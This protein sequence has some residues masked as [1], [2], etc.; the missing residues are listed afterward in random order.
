MTQIPDYQP[1]PVARGL[2]IGCLLAAGLVVGVVLWSTW[3]PGWEA[4]EREQLRSGLDFPELDIDAA[5]LQFARD[6]FAG[7]TNL[8]LIEDEL[9][10]LE[11]VVREANRAQFSRDGTDIDESSEELRQQLVFLSNDVATPTGPRGFQQAGIAI[12]DACQSGLEDLLAEV[13]AGNLP[14]EQAIDD[15]P[16]QRFEEY[17]ANCGDYL[18]VLR[19]RGLVDADGHWTRSSASELAE[20]LQR[21]RWVHDLQ[22]DKYSIHMLMSPEELE[23]FYRW[24]IEDGDAFDADQRLSYLHSA[25]PLLPDDY[26]AP[27][28]EARIKASTEDSDREKRQHFQELIDDYPENDLYR[29]IYDDAF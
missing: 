19:H 21:Y 5:E 2:V 16:E 27:L 7:D 12:I 20:I 17:R 24:R 22:G 9:Q 29:A 1:E 23:V 13:R 10:Q 4:D 14:M 6:E 28:A 11:D 25:L 26:D 15:P 3:M 8:D 18:P